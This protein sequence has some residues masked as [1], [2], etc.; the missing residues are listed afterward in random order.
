MDAIRSDD[1]FDLKAVADT[2]PKRLRRRTEAIP[3]RAYEDYRSLVVETAH[4]GLDL[5]VVALQPFQS[6]GFLE[7]AA[8]RRIPVFHQAPFARSV[9]EGRRV[10]SRFLE[11]ACPFVVSR[12]WQFDPAFDTLRALTAGRS[13]V[14]AAT[15]RVETSDTSAG[16]RGDSVRAGGGVLLNGAYEAVDMLVHLLGL[17][18]TV[19][20]QCAVRVK[21]PA[22]RPYDTE[23]AALLSLSFSR[24]RI[25][26]VTAIRG[27]PEAS[28]RVTLVDAEQTLDVTP[29]RLTITPRDKSPAQTHTVWSKYPVVHALGAFA[30]QLTSDERAFAS[31]GE[32]HLKTL[33]VIEAA[34]LSAKTAEP[35]SPN[36]LLG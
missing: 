22:P 8:D 15:A 9:S 21:P 4:A 24:E 19:Y 27:A 12:W 30:E 10:V 33:A 2:D 34:Y 7:M 35:E 16:W 28:F 26:Q 32:E 3:A 20:A 1:R 14:H 29:E 18:E 31:T 17:P 6:L 36:R 13:Y 11:K 25:A 5:L 23:D